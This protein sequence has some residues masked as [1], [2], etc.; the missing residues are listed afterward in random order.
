MRVI[1]IN[2]NTHVD[3]LTLGEVYDVV[4]QANETYSLVDDDGFQWIYTKDKFKTE[5]EV[6]NEQLDKILKWC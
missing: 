5:Q 6:R 4:Y 3:S 2:R 1:C